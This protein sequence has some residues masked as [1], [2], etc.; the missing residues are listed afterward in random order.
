MALGAMTKQESVGA[1]GPVFYDRISFAGDG[2]YPTGGTP[3]FQTAIQA[4]LKAG[5]KVLTVIPGDCGDNLVTYDSANDKLKCR[6]ASTGAEVA[7]AANLSA[8]TFNLT[9]VTY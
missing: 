2:A 6:V 4:L 9:V 1:V 3:G 5:R 8:V 7:N